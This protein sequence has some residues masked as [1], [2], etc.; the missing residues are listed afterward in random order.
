[1]YYRRIICDID[2]TISFC[3]NRDWENAKPNIELINKLNSLYD[4]GWEICYYTA[5]GHLSFNGDRTSAKNY[6]EPIILNWFKKHNVKFTELSF[7]K[8]LGSYYIDDKSIKPEEFLELNINIL[9]GG[10]SGAIIE[11]RGN[12]VYKT[13]KNSL[14]S[15]QWY[16][17]ASNIIKT[18]KIYSVIGDTLCMEYIE[19]T[20]EPKIEQIEFILEKF[21]NIAS[22]NDFN[23]YISRIKEHLNIYKP[24]YENSVIGIL[25]ENK[26]FFNKQKTFCHGDM[27]LDNM[28]CSNNILY[29]IDPIYPRDLYSSWLLDLGKIL[30][31]AKRF[32]K[33]LIYNYFINKYDNIKKYLYIIELTHWIRMRKYSDDVNY[34]DENILNL[35]KKLS[36]ME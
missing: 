16:S 20:D 22:K 14:E 24:D 5:R 30:H 19:K 23:S 1:M 33:P 15:A 9:K 18:I 13:H 8:P 4:D 27:S 6:Y 32:N 7:D 26:D 34:I 11:R 25:L 10:L 17:E 36:W 28:I 2:D 3:I 21:K 31:S 12:K 29:L 35:L